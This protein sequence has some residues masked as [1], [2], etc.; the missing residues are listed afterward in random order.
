M[1]S[2]VIWLV[3]FAFA[4]LKNKQKK[5]IRLK[6]DQGVSVDMPFAGES[7]FLR[8]KQR[9]LLFYPAGQKKGVPSRN[10]L[11][12][13]RCPW[14]VQILTFMMTLWISPSEIMGMC[15]SSGK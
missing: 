13:I 8:L 1:L 7:L 3:L 2:I 9:I 10:A 11:F 14:V 5:D 15:A 4:L 12:L 6:I